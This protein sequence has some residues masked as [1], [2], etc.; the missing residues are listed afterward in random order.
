MSILGWILLGGL[1]A[2]GMWQIGKFI[3]EVSRVEKTFGAGSIF[4]VDG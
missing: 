4:R 3:K 2:S 1:F